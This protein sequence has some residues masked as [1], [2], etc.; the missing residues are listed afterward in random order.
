MMIG[1][2][3]IG[4][5]LPKK[6]QAVYASVGFYAGLY[7]ERNILVSDKVDHRLILG[8]QLGHKIFLNDKG[9]PNISFASI[10]VIGL[11]GKNNSFVELGLG[12]GVVMR[13]NA[14][15]FEARIGPKIILGYRWESEKIMY[16]L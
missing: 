2:K 15:A 13:Y 14:E 16:R 5:E 3:L 8:A 1:N 10:H 7:Y 12:P 6:Q 9:D 4:Q 11:L